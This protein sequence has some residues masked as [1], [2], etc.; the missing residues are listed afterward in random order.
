[1]ALRRDLLLYYWYEATSATTLYRPVMFLYFRALGFSWTQVAILEAVGS[2]VTVATEVPTGYVGDRVGR[3]T[4]P[5]AGTALIA[6]ALRP[7]DRR[8]GRSRGN[9]SR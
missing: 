7:G 3:R 8:D 5:F 2:L 1:M 4:S 9:A 6:V